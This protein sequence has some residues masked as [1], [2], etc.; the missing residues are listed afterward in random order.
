MT[1]C[2]RS[3]LDTTLPAKAVPWWVLREP[4][5][6]NLAWPA[7]VLQIAFPKSGDPQKELSN[8]TA[9]RHAI[10]TL[11]DLIA[12]FDKVRAEYDGLKKI[13]QASVAEPR[14]PARG[15]RVKQPRPV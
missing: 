6:A 8:P 12:E 1:P 3:Y 11:F 2:L 5:G 4:S 14:V 9:E 15:G 10:D 7:L 13:F